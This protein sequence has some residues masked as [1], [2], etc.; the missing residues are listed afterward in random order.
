MS[1]IKPNLGEMRLTVQIPPGP[2]QRQRSMSPEAAPSVGIRPR[3]AWFRVVFFTLAL[4]GIFFAIFFGI[5]RYVP[6]KARAIE[7][8]PE[9]QKQ[10]ER[11]TPKQYSENA[12]LPPRNLSLFD[13][14]LVRDLVKTAGSTWAG[15]ILII[16]VLMAG[17]IWR[18]IYIHRWRTGTSPKKNTRPG[19]NAT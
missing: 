14:L 16:L 19:V 9:Q 5:S 15:P 3:R 7:S 18:I 8:Q 17:T 2:A 1:W 10:Q 6:Y 4:F 12:S 13:W 11:P